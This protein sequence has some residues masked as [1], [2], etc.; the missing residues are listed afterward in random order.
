MRLCAEVAQSV[1]H[2]AENA[3]VA[4]SI[5][6]LGT[7]RRQRRW[8]RL[9]PQSRTTSGQAERKWLSGRASPCQ[10]EG[11]GFDPRLPLQAIYLRLQ[12]QCVTPTDALTAT[13][14]AIGVKSGLSSGSER[15]DPRL[16]LS[17][18]CTTFHRS[19]SRLYHVRPPFS[20]RWNGA[21]CSW[22][23]RSFAVASGLPLPLAVCPVPLPLA[24]HSAL[25]AGLAVS[26]LTGAL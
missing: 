9:M 17:A 13:L 21:P 12:Q 14:T 8:R 4:S 18:R 26:T 24:D 11:H 6:A 23:L 15:P 7:A 2:S 5:L 3:G 10:G 19:N 25:A 16:R 1:E 20:C 22:Q